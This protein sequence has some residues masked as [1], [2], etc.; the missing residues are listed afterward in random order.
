[1][2]FFID[3]E[4]TQFSNGIISIGCVSEEGEKFS[5]FVHTP[6]KITPFITD[7]TGI[8]AEDNEKAPSPEVVFHKFFYWVSSQN[9]ITEIPHFYCYGTN[10]KDFVK[11]NFL[12]CNNFTAKAMLSYLY[13]DL[14]DYSPKVKEHFGLC[15]N[16]GLNKVYNY[17][18][19]QNNEQQHSAVEDAYMLWKV[20]KYIQENED[21]QDI[22]PEYQLDYVAPTPGNYIVHRLRDGSIIETYPSMAAAIKWCLMQMPVND[23]RVVKSNTISKSIKKAARNKVRYRTYDWQIDKETL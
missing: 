7:L 23:R 6:Y 18:T 10:D 8:T 3:F 11:K 13:T 9:P 16:I 12:D 21:E 15:R 14:E 22:F 5:S 4:A 20:Y 19:N 1:M 2:N 17:C